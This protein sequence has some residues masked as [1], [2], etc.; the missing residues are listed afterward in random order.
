MDATI[1][2][3][4][5]GGQVIYPLGVLRVA[6]AFGLKPSEVFNQQRKANNLVNGENKPL[7]TSSIGTKVVDGLSPINREVY[8]KS[9]KFRST[10]MARRVASGI[11]G[12]IPNYVRGSMKVYTVGNIGPTSTGP[13]LDVKR[14]DGGRF[15]ANALDEFVIVHDPEFGNVSLG[16]IRERTGGI[17]DN[18][19]QHVARG[20]HGIDYGIHDGTELSITNGAKVVSNTPTEHGDYL[21]IELPNGDQYS[22]LHGKGMM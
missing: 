8:M 6:A 7:L 10:K 18:W 21:I 9:Q 13:H 5:S 4:Q 16:E 22:F 14:V 20:S 17:G 2:S 3:A 15:E 12:T 19:D 1:V 11:D